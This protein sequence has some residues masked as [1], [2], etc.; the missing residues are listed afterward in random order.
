MNIGSN[1]GR[2]ISAELLKKLDARGRYILSTKSPQTL[3]ALIKVTKALS[4]EQKREISDI[5]VALH[6]DVGTVL[7]VRIPIDKLSQ[8]LSLDYVL[9]VTVAQ[10]LY[11]E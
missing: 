3:L 4:P 10:P 9:Q 8:F 2:Q 11:L 1:D 6:A 5:G 7:T